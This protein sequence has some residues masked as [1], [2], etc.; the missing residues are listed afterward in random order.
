IWGEILSVAAQRQGAVGA[1]IDGAARDRPEIEALGFALYARDERV[2]GPYG[3]A[4]VVAIDEPVTIM[5][6]HGT[7]VHGNGINVRCGDIVVADDT[8]LVCLDPIEG[9][10]IVA[11]AVRYAMGEAAVVAALNNGELLSSAYRNKQ[12]VVQAISTVS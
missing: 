7:N 1:A 12:Q 10:T 2:V 8:G 9:E 5:N 11:D 6:S 3:T 4:H